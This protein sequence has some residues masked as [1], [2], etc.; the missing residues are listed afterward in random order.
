MST[1]LPMLTEFTLSNFKS[2]RNSRLMIGSLTVMIGANASGKSNIL[3]ALRFLHWL[4]N[5]YQLSA[6]QSAINID[7]FI[8]G[9]VDDLCYQGESSFTIGCHLDSSEW[10]QFEITI[11]VHEGE[12]KITHEQI[13]GANDLPLYTYI[14]DPVIQ[15]ERKNSQFLHY[16]D[17]TFNDVSKSNGDSKVQCDNRMAIF[18][19]LDRSAFT[20]GD[21]KRFQTNS[22]ETIHQYQSTLQ[23]ILFLEAIPNKMRGY[24]YKSDLVFLKDGSNL[25]SILFHLWEN[26]PDERQTILNL[27]QSLPEQAID[28]LDFIFGPRNE[29]MV[30][31]SETFG[32]N[33]HY[34]EAALLSDGTL[35]VLAIAAAM[36]YVLEGSLVVI[37][38]IDNGI[39]PS[40]AQHLITSIQ[41]IAKRRN[42]RVLISTH[43]PALMDAIPN[44]A[45]GDVVFCYRDPVVGDSRLVRLGDLDDLPSLILQGS[46]G[47]LVTKGVVDRFVKSPHTPED[48][49]K[50][51]LAWL[52]RMQEY[53]NE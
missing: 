20:N 52:T 31:L 47:N 1:M 28:G 50:K 4:A 46:L 10:N 15:E 12:M 9:R 18:T 26:K 39:H 6:I 27:I 53:S 24:S 33:R 7:R 49:K 41:E 43:N 37:E 44:D 17:V 19:Q 14:V 25:S 51:A 3:E 11:N 40:R 36:L 13:A 34:Y 2:Y 38:E 16:I 29:V 8:R 42:L 32:H 5:G 48:K 35:R 23:N 21:L 30:R 22:R 45:L